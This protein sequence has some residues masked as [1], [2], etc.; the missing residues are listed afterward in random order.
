[1]VGGKILCEAA[2]CKELVTVQTHDSAPNEGE[3]LGEICMFATLSAKLPVHS[4][5]TI[6]LSVMWHDVA[7]RAVIQPDNADGLVCACI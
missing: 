6:Q 5:L 1:L 3:K 2:G 7:R 4:I